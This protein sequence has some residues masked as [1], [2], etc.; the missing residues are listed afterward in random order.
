MSG[1]PKVQPT[2]LQR[3][4]VVYL[5]QSSPKQVL[6]NRESGLN[7]RALRERLL[8]LGWSKG[9]I[10]VIDDD[11]GLSAKHACG[12]EGFQKLAADVGLRKVGIILGYEVSRLSRNNADWHRLLELCSL[13]DTLIGDADGIYN[14][15]D[16][17]DRLLLGLKGTMSEAEL[18]SLR[19]R[20][21]AGRLSKARRGEL[22]HHLPTGLARGP[23][24]SVHF[25]PDQSVQDRIRLVF[26]R[27]R[28]LGS[29]QKVLRH[30]ARNGLKLPRRQTSGLYAGQVLWKDPSPS[31][32]HSIL[33]NPAYAGAFAYGRR[34]ADPSHQVPGRPATGKIRQPRARWLALVPGVY[35]AYISWEEHEQIQER[36]AENRQQMAERLT[37][38][39]AIRSGAAL[40]TGLVRCG[41]CG[42]AMQVSYKDRRFQYVCQNGQS[43]YARPNCQ[44]LSGS[45][46]DEA[47]VGEF[48]RVL[49]PAQ[50]DVLEQVNSRQAEH[51]HDL[52]RHLEQEVT[53]LDYAAKRAERQ[54][55]CVD[56]ENRLIAAS[57]EKK[58]E[59]AL[60]ELEQA[61]TRL[62]EAQAHGAPPAPVPA[63]L[64][65]AF[66][67]V[68]R[69]LPEVWPGLSAEAKKQLLRTLVTGV[70]LQRDGNGIL[71]IRIA[72]RGG[73]V[74]EVSVR[75][76]VSSR[77]HSE[78]ERAIVQRIRELAEGGLT[79][80]AIARRLNG[81]GYHPCRSAAFSREIVL[82]LRCRHHIRLG[83]ARVRA[84]DLPAAYTVREM[85]GL[86]GVDVSWIYRGICDGRIAVEKD[87]QYGC[88]LFPRNQRAIASLKRLKAGKVAQ[89]SFP[90][91]HRDG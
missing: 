23:D 78:V 52:V 20:L 44:Y 88:Y 32:V 71:Q 89:V 51:Q 58:W 30:L 64:R 26:A 65:G 10:L 29:A 39:Q 6:N 21:D 18:H 45:R 25:D 4:A 22:V 85:A 76:P 67:D 86:L 60:A 13:F 43:K 84:G 37:R 72:W 41:R 55:N 38:K 59:N 74:S 57:L 50:I 14:P 16:F 63:E 81:E 35:P 40:L 69:R 15:R 42:H 83:L 5:R 48:F 87:P 36:I 8:E 11:Q 79:D 46:I 19:L 91:E 56:P 2:H 73:L 54:Y 66:A 28:E 3:Q 75:V 80:G 7:Q 77:R 24:G 33:K 47:V 31:A 61:R 27:F 9:Q 49:Q 53:R 17:N 34:T 12:R 62:K 70:N 68:G 82:K 1:S 90:K